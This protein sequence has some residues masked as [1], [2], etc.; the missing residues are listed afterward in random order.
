MKILVFS[1]SHHTLGAM[2]DAVVLEQPDCVLHLGD[3]TPDA[4]DLSSA[5]DGL[6]LTFVPGNC[7]YAPTAA[8]SLL[9]EIGGVRIFL[10]HGHLFGVKSGLTR[11]E[12]EARRLGAQIALFG[13]THRPFLE[14]RDG[15][16][17]MNPGSCSAISADYGVI[18]AENG[19]FSCA[20]KTL[21]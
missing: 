3:C 10:T 2:Y 5:F 15:L 7:D 1:D 13:H 19:R 11:L 8:P 20:L 18:T 21:A 4:E 6:D 16:V 17:L 9:R 14:E 12:L